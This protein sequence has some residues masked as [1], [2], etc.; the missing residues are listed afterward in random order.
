MSVSQLCEVTDIDSSL[1]HHH[2]KFLKS[3][4]TIEH[5]YEHKLGDSNYSYYRLTK[6][7]RDF[8]TKILGLFYPVLTIKRKRLLY[9]EE[10]ETSIPLEG[11][12]IEGEITKEVNETGEKMSKFID[13]LIGLM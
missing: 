7:G 3:K 13:E 6:Y 1:I 8:I 9:Y 12:M 11:T 5:F 4:L 10:T 2:L